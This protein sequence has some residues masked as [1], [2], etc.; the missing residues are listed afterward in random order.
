MLIVLTERLMARR[1][2][3]TA[4]AFQTEARTLASAQRRIRA[5]FVFMLGGELGD[6]HD[7][8]GDHDDHDDHGGHDH[9]QDAGGAQDEMTR[10]H[11]EAHARAD[12]DVLEGRMANQGRVELV[13]AIQSMSHAATFLGDASMEDALRA[14]QTALIFLQRAFS[15][16]RY[17]LRAFSERERLDPERRLTG[18]LAEA[19]S[20][21]RSPREEPVDSGV[22]AMRR[23]LARAAA[24]NA[25]AG[26]GG[27]ADP[28]ALARDL[29]AVD[30][31]DPTLLEVAALLADA[32]AAQ[33][34]GRSRDARQRLDEAVAL[35]GRHVRQQLR[36]APVHEPHALQR[37]EGRLTD[38]LRGG[39]AR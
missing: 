21:R 37:L 29:L 35:L 25:G 3:M 1:G 26:V 27:G 32:G 36:P 28:S 39:G 38:M 2:T 16:S 8:A 14:E 15:R 7:A 4:D 23:I 10:L 22:V 31:T 34:A 17:I 19:A 24:A 9:A 30:A 12:L 18:T 5:E 11:E 13:R 6:D 20:Q 33:G